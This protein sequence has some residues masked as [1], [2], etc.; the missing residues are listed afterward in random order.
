MK[1]FMLLNSVIDEIEWLI[2]GPHFFKISQHLIEHSKTM[3][4]EASYK[5]ASLIE[6]G[7]D[8]QAYSHTYIQSLICLYILL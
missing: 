2:C 4:E 3:I 7:Y 8:T 6:E 5:G 1:I